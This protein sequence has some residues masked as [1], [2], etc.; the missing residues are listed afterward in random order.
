[1]N[2]FEQLMREVLQAPQQA[3]PAALLARELAFCFL[4][5]TKETK[6]QSEIAKESNYA[7]KFLLMAAEYLQKA[8][9]LPPE[10]AAEYCN[11]SMTLLTATLRSA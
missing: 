4:T 10:F 7:P 9:K 3:L 11:R 1:M 6:L 8:L 2:R 5:S